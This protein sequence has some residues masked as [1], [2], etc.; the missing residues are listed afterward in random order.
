MRCSAFFW[1][2]CF[3]LNLFCLVS[4]PLPGS[5]PPPPKEVQTTAILV[6]KLLQDHHF[7]GKP[8][9]E[10]KAREWVRAYMESLDYNHAF[11]LD[12][13]L[14]A[15]QDTYGPQLAKL[16]QRG[17]ISPAYEIFS[18]FSDRVRSRLDWIRTRLTLP[19]DFSLDQTYEIDRTRVGWPADHTSADDLWDRRLKFDILR[20]KLVTQTNAKTG[21]KPKEENPLETVSKRYDR[22]LRNLEDYDS[23]E[24][25]QLYLT[26]LA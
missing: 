25:S 23:E 26:A 16:T 3:W 11:F 22:L 19:F 4:S 10:E 9:T 7:S 2:G 15:Y 17:D 24:I 8:L 13:D 14:R 12:A 5:P 1:R 21:K 6:Q 20:E 18:G